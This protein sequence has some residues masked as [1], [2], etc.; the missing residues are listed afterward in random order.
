MSFAECLINE[1]IWYVTIQIWLLS[2]MPLIFIHVV[3]CNISSSLIFLFLLFYCMDV[4][5]YVFPFTSW[6]TFGLFPFLRIVVNRYLFTASPYKKIIFFSLWYQ[7]SSIKCEQKYLYSFWIKAL[8]NNSWFFFM[9]FPPP[10]KMH[11]PNRAA[12]SAEI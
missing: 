6:Y 5:Q 1:I 4:P 9:F 7:D 12:P 11:V 3:A 2:I 10:W 8:R